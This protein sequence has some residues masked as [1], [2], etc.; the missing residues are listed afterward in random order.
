ME[1]V[2]SEPGVIYGT[3]H[4]PGYV[5]AEGLGGSVDLELDLSAGF[6]EY[7]MEWEPDET[8]VFPQPLVVEY[9]RV[10]GAGETYER[11]EA[12]FVDDFTGWRQ[13]TLPFADFVRSAQQP[14]GAPDDGLDL[15]QINGFKVNLPARP[16]KYYLDQFSLAD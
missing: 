2:G 5:G 8:T 3:A 14:R 9:V 1:F 12:G 16:E 15:T 7:A 10:Y 4:G 11:F 6:H 13:V